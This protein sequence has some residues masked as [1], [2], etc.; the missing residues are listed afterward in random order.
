MPSNN[1]KM[2]CNS[3][4]KEENKHKKQTVDNYNKLIR[5][6]EE[7]MEN[8]RH[9]KLWKDASNDASTNASSGLIHPFKALQG[10]IS[11]YPAYLQKITRPYNTARSICTAHAEQ[12]VHY[13]DVVASL[14]VGRRRRNRR[15]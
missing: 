9:T 15:S 6:E 13:D 7:T 5:T 3:N 2:T 8:E 1:D 14:T 10:P 12:R 4:N 11:P